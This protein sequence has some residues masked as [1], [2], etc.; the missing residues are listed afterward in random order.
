M[1]HKTGDGINTH[2]KILVFFSSLYLKVV[3]KVSI[4]TLL[5]EEKKYYKK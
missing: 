3:M 4:K 5:L 1:E 2:F